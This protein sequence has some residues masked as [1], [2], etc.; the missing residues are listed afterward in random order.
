MPLLA[1]RHPAHILLEINKSPCPSCTALLSKLTDDH[2]GT[3]F[4]LHMLGLY[5]GAGEAEG[6][7]GAATRPQDLVVL[8]QKL[9]AKLL[10]LRAV[11]ERLSDE[12]WKRKLKRKDTKISFNTRNDALQFARSVESTMREGREKLGGSQD[13]TA[14]GSK[15]KDFE[16]TFERL[17][18]F[19]TSARAGDKQSA[20]Y[21][22]YHKPETVQAKPT[23]AT[24][25]VR[26]LARWT[27]IKEQYA[28][29]QLQ[30]EMYGEYYMY[31]SQSAF[32]WFYVHGT[33][34]E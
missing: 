5:P 29:L 17:V 14:Y 15:L 2:P 21:E 9:Q 30:Q 28:D 8:E 31:W 13:Q 32:T 3:K 19:L 10:D 20:H 24:E 27:E 12:R 23:V 25:M 33:L 1:A 11:V 26:D 16:A 22:P 4:E 34:P 6:E 18:T 7:R